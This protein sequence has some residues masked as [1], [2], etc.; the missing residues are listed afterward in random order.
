[1]GIT[2][3]AQNFEDVILW[4]ALGDVAGG[5]YVDVGA[6]DPISDSVS[7]AFY[8]RGWRGIHIEPQ[9]EFAQRLRKDRPED[10]IIQAIVADTPG[11][12]TFY[13]VPDGKGL[14]TASREIAAAHTQLRG[15]AV[16]ETN[17]AAI[18]LDD[19]L[20]QAPNGIVHWLKIDVEG[21][22]TQVLKGWHSACRPWVIVIEAT[23]P[24][25]QTSSH[26]EW[27]SLVLEKGYDFVYQDGLNR[28]Y[29]HQ[30]HAG[31]TPSFRYPPNVH[32]G[33]ELRAGGMT[34][35]LRAELGNAVN[36]ANVLMNELNNTR[37]YAE[38]MRRD[39]DSHRKVSDAL[40]SHLDAVK[41]EV[42]ALRERVRAIDETKNS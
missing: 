12:V 7:K 28:F 17:V 37:Q 31:R 21:F 40:L 29:L 22:E 6:H 3:Y 27:E 23:A 16:K 26:E 34:K 11:S 5:F 35:G 38:E 14:A 18:T 13:E 20:K 33:F 32:D 10:Q 24:L 2:S 41:I 42:E 4:R 15:Y 1:M 9:D 30:Q 8:E 36:I 39:I 19:V 25:E